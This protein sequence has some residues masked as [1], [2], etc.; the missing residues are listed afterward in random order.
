MKNCILFCLLILLLTPA[1]VLTQHYSSESTIAHTVNVALSQLIVSGSYYM[2][3]FE[4]GMNISLIEPCKPTYGY[5]EALTVPNNIIRACR[6]TVIG[7]PWIYDNGTIGF[8]DTLGNLIITELNTK[9][10]NLQL[11]FV[12]VSIAQNGY[13][14]SLSDA[15][16]AGQCDIGISAMAIT[17]NR[18]QYVDFG[19]AHSAS[20]MAIMRGGLDSNLTLTD[21]SQ[22]NHSHV[23]LALLKGSVWIRIAAENCP[24]ANIIQLDSFSDCLEAVKNEEVHATLLPNVVVKY[25]LNLGSCPACEGYEFGNAPLQ[26]G[27]F[28]KKGVLTG[29]SN[30]TGD[31]AK[32]SYGNSWLLFSSLLA[33]ITILF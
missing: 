22:L 16:N 32:I 20:W 10:H 23:K 33:F 6:D 4:F 26:F 8:Y 2:P 18:K 5:P 15:I 27:V 7:P 31:A 19:C 25:W 21:T 11:Q 13:S 14:T 28:F 29:G 3:I 30:S 1:I 9:Y 12:D 24:M 17:T